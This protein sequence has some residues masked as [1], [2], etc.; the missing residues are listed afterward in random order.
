[1]TDDG[2]RPHRFS[3]GQ[4]FDEDYSDFS[5]DPPELSVD[6]TKV[7]PVDSRV[8]TDILD[9]R[10]IDPEDVDVEQLL[11]VGLSYMQINRFEEATEA[12][13][14]TARFAEDGSP[15]QQEAW[16]NKGAAHAQ[17]EEWDEAIGSYHE[18]LRVDDDSEHAA[19]THT[20]LAY[21]L[22]ES[23]R[24]ADALDHAERAVELDPRFA[25]AWYNRGFFLHERGLNEDAVN[26]FD[27]AIRLGMRTPAVHEEKARALEELGREEAAE[28]AQQ[29]ADDIRE[30]AEAELVEDY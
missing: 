24:T 13:E 7:D 9:Q 25:Q 3:E 6:P 22:W 19:T 12:F 26:A 4:G 29:Q 21:A 16:V 18:A 15:L 8:L 23:G 28:Q 30:Q 14:R 5:L 27:N 20:N 10:N 2:K 1:M 11:D 17:L